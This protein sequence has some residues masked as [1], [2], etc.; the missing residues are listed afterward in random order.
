METSHDL[1][2]SEFRKLDQLAPLLG[3]LVSK[4]SGAGDVG[5]LNGVWI[6][7]AATQQKLDELMNQVRVRTA[8]ASSLGKTEMLLSFLT[9]INPAGGERRNLV[10]KQVGIIRAGRLLGYLGLGHLG[11]VHHQF[12]AFDQRPLDRLLVT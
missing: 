1:L 4:D 2:N 8:M 10:R 6:P 3:R 11:G 12:L 5:G 9:S 7:L